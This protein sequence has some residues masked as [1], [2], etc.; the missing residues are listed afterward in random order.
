MTET[1][2]K[3]SADVAVAV[4]L[5]PRFAHLHVH[6]E[7]SLVDGMIRIDDLISRAKAMGHTHIALTDS[8]N[9]FGALEFYMAAKAKGIIP[10]VGCQI[11]HQGSEL[12]HTVAAALSD[13]K[14]PVGAFHLLL[15]AK[16]TEGYKRLMKIV[17]AGYIG[18]VP[19]SAPIIKESCLDNNANADLVAILAAEGSEFAYLV[20]Q[21]R[22]L[23]PGVDLCWQDID[24]EALDLVHSALAET[25][26]KMRSR[27]GEE[28]IYV[29][30]CDNNIPGQEQERVDLAAAAKHFGLPIVATGNVYYLNPDD[31]D[32]HALLTAI[33]NSY[34][35]TDI[36]G[37]LKNVKF[38][39]ASDDEMATAFAA[40]PEAITNA[41]KIAEACSSLKIEMGKYYLPKFETGRAE[42]SD[43]ALARLSREGLEERLTQLSPLY[44]P[45]FTEE[46]KGEYR[47]R[48]EY[49]L[50]VII[51]MGFPGYFLI[52]QDFINWAK[53]RDI[54][55]GPGR[56]SGAGSLVAYSL[57]ITDLDPIPYTLLFER[58]LNPD[59]ISMPDFDVDFCQWRRDEVIKYV[60]E[61]YGAT[62]VAQITTFGK[63]MAKGAVKS[64]GRA[65][66]LGYNRVDRFTKLFPDVLNITL[67]DALA[68]E[69]K[70]TAEIAKDDALKEVMDYAFKVEGLTSHTSVHAAGIVISDGPMTDYVPVYTTDGTN[71]ITQYEMKKAEKVGLVKFD[72]LGL[73]TLT[74]IRKAVALI[75]QGPHKD[76]TIAGIPLDDKRVY[77]FTSSGATCGLFQ[78]ESLGMTKLVM[79]LKPSCF[80]DIIALV[81]LFRPGPLG[82]GMVDDFVERKHGRQEITYQHPDL[83]P[84]LC[85]T[86]GMILYQEQV[87]KIAAILANYTLGEADLL[88]RAMGKKD[89]KEMEKQKSRFLSGASENNIDPKIAGE[90][91]ELMAEFANYGFN[92]SHSAAYG[93]V[94]YQTAYLKTHF[95]EEFMAAIMTCDLDNTAKITRYVED[96][97]RMGFKIFP[98]NINSS[99]LDFSVPAR[100]HIGFGLAAI[101]GIGDAV[102][103][104]L[105]RERDLNGPF[106]NLADLCLRVDLGKIGKK[107]LE[108][109]TQAGALDDFCFPRKQLLS[110]LK[111][112]VDYS[113]KHFEA[114]SQGQ[115]SLFDFDQPE[116]SSTA[117]GISWVQPQSAVQVLFDNDDL[118]TERKLLGAFLSGHP[119]DLYAADIESLRSAKISDFPKIADSIQKHKRGRSETAIVALLTNSN[120]RRTKSGNLMA[121]F[122]LE[123]PG[124]SI[125]GVMF[126]KT[127][128]NQLIPPHDTP[129]VAY[130]IVDRS[131]DGSMLR[132][133]LNRLVPLEEARQQRVKS[134]LVRIE[135]YDD[136][137]HSA[138]IAAGVSQLK[139]LIA[140]RPG[141]T[142]FR[143]HLTLNDAEVLIDPTGGSG[144]ELTDQLLFE[145]RK[146]PFNKVSAQCNWA[147]P[148]EDRTE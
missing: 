17:S 106:K 48:L 80:E 21:I 122:R 47:T 94:S 19:E 99:L 32:T 108:L 120:E 79:K 115:R 96:C 119:L 64:V 70:L 65:L 25:V 71:L 2:A 114:K 73:K 75:H 14:P 20:K 29:E 81:A 112:A 104:P 74:V 50:S 107:T 62:N 6:S 33:K 84:I 147:A 134:L 54:P 16:N 125:E 34:T 30:L 7:Y 69:P 78:L 146:L 139:R 44:G 42:N 27:F 97:Q 76:F 36:R 59:R 28:N 86:Y 46:K 49:E 101:K 103:R 67:T 61:K 66:N 102:L 109:L 23:S 116:D 91:F 129:V 87:Q 5:K 57:R 40:W 35:A 141:P 136:S 37:R 89:P 11:F 24:N 45:T 110:L 52:V 22:A 105:L 95:A 56:G 63:L 137:P 93:L 123:Q 98:P 41:L 13:R 130:G 121:S 68:Q 117:E 126:E 9:M 4:E 100:K 132:F 15:L 53:E 72:F 43:E 77:N 138:K 124:S 131:F 88:R 12:S 55:V 144:V 18:Q 85:D 140:D 142:P 10:I 128:K 127:L 31:G 145:M 118:F 111:D 51:R 8:A 92:K 133:T 1:K 143:I 135:H 90:I 60:T 113:S 82:S 38:H 58:F 39:L 26:R 148:S 83:E 3:P